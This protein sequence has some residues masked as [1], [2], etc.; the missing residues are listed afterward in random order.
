V[1]RRYQKDAPRDWEFYTFPVAF[2][3]V[4]GA[5]IAIFLASLIPYGLLFVVTLF[6][7]SFGVAHILSRLMRRRTLDRRR[8]ADEE[9]ERERRALAAREA[10]LQATEEPARR[11]RRRRV[12]RGQTTGDV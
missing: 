12:R 3:F 8:Q 7:T 2:A 6:G 10:S 1:S 4:A 5:F 9:H 11:R